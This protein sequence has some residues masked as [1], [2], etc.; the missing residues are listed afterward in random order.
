MIVQISLSVSYGIDTAPL[1]DPNIAIAE[2]ALH[3]V[4]VAQERA[5]ILNLLPSRKPNQLLLSCFR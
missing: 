3:S 5:R 2:T 4:D 1:N